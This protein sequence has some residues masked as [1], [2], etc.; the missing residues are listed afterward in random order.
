MKTTSSTP[1]AQCTICATQ[2]PDLPNLSIKDVARQL[3]KS[4]WTVRDLVRYGQ[5]PAYKL[6]TGRNAPVR[7]K[8]SDV[9]GLFTPVVPKQRRRFDN[10]RF[11]ADTNETPVGEGEEV[12]P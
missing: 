2:S 10:D 4:H 5:L 1:P 12:V 9:N 11:T 7:I 8:Q 6:G 3:G